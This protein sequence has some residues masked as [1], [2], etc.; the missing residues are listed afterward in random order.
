MLQ[1]VVALST[2]KADYT[3]FTEAVKEA[4]WLRGLLEELDWKLHSWDSLI[5][6]YR[7]FLRFTYHGIMFFM[8]GL[9]ISICLDEG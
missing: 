2:T 5:C 7:G 1:H 4:I 9:S 3:A 8:R 6:D